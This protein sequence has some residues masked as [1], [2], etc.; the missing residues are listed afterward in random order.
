MSAA[1]PQPYDPTSAQP[2][3]P[4]AAP[5]T[6]EPR[7]SPFQGQPGINMTNMGAATRGGQIAGLFDNVLRGFVNGMAQGQKHKALTLKKKSDDLTASYNADAQRAYEY[8]R[9]KVAQDGKLD[10]ND[11]EYQKLKSAVDGSWGA[12][13][14]FRGTL[15][16]QS[17]GKKKG[18]KQ[19]QQLPPVA[20]LTN[21]KST[22]QEKAQAYYDLSQ[23]AGPPLFGQIQSLVAWAQS[24]QA[25]QQRKTQADT[26][27]AQGSQASINRQLYDKVNELSGLITKPNPTDDEKQHIA[28]LK[29][30]ITQIREAVNPTKIPASGGPWYSTQGDD[31]K[32]Y[33][34]KKDAEGNEVP[35]TRRPISVASAGNKPI[36]AFIMGPNKK[37]LAVMLDPSTNQVVPGSE[38]PEIIPPSSML[39]HVSNGFITY[40]DPETQEVHLV[41]VQ[42]ST[43]PVLPSASLPPEHTENPDHP[44]HPDHKGVTPKTVDT[45]STHSDV[46]IGHK[47]PPRAKIDQ[48]DK[49]TN[50]AYQKAVDDFNKSVDALS[51]PNLH[52]TP[53]QIA[54]A[55]KK[56]YNRLQ[57]ENGEIGKTHSQRMRDLGLIP[58]EDSGG[59]PAESSHASDPMGIL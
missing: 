15:L 3:T 45:A 26:G 54:G 51:D 56:F 57:E 11:P 52:L 40:T 7:E 38:N 59:K 24:P 14:D 29:S 10:P 13:Q 30:Q 58:A 17:G 37:P 48:L 34:F 16:E 35:D 4:V 44:N 5:P 12:L 50:A 25:Q 36:R 43:A 55:K 23:K 8:A 32:W 53:D 41:P 21:P 39:Q 42:R 6:P 18:K 9:Q 33:E 1:A 2:Y 27:A 31:K 20:V 49:E 19:D 46:V 47:G 22:Q 28:E